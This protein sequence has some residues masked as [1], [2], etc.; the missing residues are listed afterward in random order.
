MAPD[1]RPPGSLCVSV[2]SSGGLQVH[3]CARFARPRVH[4]QA[5]TAYIWPSYLGHLTVS[6][7][8]LASQKSHI[9]PKANYP[10]CIMDSS[11]RPTRA[12]AS[13]CAYL[14]AC[15]TGTHSS[16]RGWSLSVAEGLRPNQWSHYQGVPSFSFSLDVSRLLIHS[17]SL[18]IPQPE[19]SSTLWLNIWNDRQNRKQQPVRTGWAIGLAR[20][21]NDKV[22]GLVLSASPYV[23]LPFRALGKNGYSYLAAGV[24]WATKTYDPFTN[25]ENNALSSHLNGTTQLGIGRHFNVGERQKL[26][27]GVHFAH[28]SNGGISMPNFGINFIG[29][30]ASYEVVATKPVWNLPERT[31][32]RR[33][34][35]DIWSGMTR[36][37][38]T[39]GGSFSS[40]F[41]TYAL[42]LG[43]VRPSGKRWLLGARLEYPGWLYRYTVYTSLYNAND[44]RRLTRRI[45]VSVGHEY[46]LGHFGLLGHIGTYAERQTKLGGG[47]IYEILGGHYY[48]ISPMRGPF[49][50]V[51]MKAH[52]T[53]AEYFQFVG[54]WRF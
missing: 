9:E 20:P 1:P 10:F 3:S 19:L 42:T 5:P 13:A 30:R 7:R 14:L 4:L 39:S 33:W 36:T 35:L 40:L 37:E 38:S 28:Y 45:A 17:P 26:S 53:V 12:S 32:N 23:Q 24:A 41:E 54:G 34:S 18:Q 48:F 46:P 43:R 44:A 6:G 21:G 49:I 29:L 8:G 51:H 47:P 16:E 27:V 15:E 2:L 22:L 11:R 31:V 52:M 25:P 50:G